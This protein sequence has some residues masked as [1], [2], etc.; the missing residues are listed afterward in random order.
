MTTLPSNIFL[1]LILF[2]NPVL[3]P[4]SPFSH[5]VRIDILA[6]PPTEVQVKLIREDID[7]GRTADVIQKVLP[8][9]GLFDRAR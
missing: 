7:V 4:E 3:V 8:N 6:K 5:L 1:A 9:R 2:S